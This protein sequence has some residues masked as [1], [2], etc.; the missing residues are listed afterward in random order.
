MTASRLKT[1]K[2][3]GPSNLN[4]LLKGNGTYKNLQNIPWNSLKS[5]ENPL[6]PRKFPENPKLSL[7]NREQ[8]KKEAKYEAEEAERKKL[9]RLK[10]S[11]KL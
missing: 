3:S 8:A 10:K 9:K 6:I 2:S 5:P 4:G 11:Q 1:C 7:E